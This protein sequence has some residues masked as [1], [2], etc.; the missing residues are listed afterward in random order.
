M[1]HCLFATAMCL[2][3]LV[4]KAQQ[5]SAPEVKAFETFWK[6]VHTAIMKKDYSAVSA[7]IEFPLVVKKSLS[8]T[9]V[10]TVGARDFA[11]FFS[12]YL[13]MPARDQFINKYGLL[14]TRRDLN[15][16]DKSMI[17]ED[18]ATMEDF[19][20]QKIDGEWKLVYVY[21]TVPE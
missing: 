17:S 16:D 15:D 18:S 1:K 7:F 11:T 21:A 20:F 19:E 10:S 13:E 12:G 2:I 4:G 8:D 6:K 5:A 3:L 9:A 14:K